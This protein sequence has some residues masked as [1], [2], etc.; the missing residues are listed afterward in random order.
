LRQS[1]DPRFENP[2]DT[3]LAAYLWL[4]QQS[5]QSL[6]K[7]VAG[8]VVLVSGFWWARKLA[9]RVVMGERYRSYSSSDAR[10]RASLTSDVRIP[11]GSSVSD[12]LDSLSIA[13]VAQ[14][15]VGF[16]ASRVI[17]QSDAGTLAMSP[18]SATSI[19]ATDT[20]AA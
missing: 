19:N 11:F 4:L 8:D 12:A 10:Y 6:A 20:L 2:W 9:L 3:A 1:R 15:D 16:L 7:L 14:S 17:L 13:R 5:S 18:R